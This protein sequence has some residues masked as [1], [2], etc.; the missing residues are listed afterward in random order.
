MALCGPARIA[1]TKV[2]GRRGY[3]YVLPRGLNV[4]ERKGWVQLMHGF[5]DGIY[6]WRRRADYAYY[7]GDHGSEA[8][9][10]GELAKGK[11]EV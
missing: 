4:E 8:R 6:Q 2:S 11:F 9:G 7:E 3:S 1:L 10:F 5:R